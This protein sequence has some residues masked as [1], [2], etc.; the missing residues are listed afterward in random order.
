[1]R[2]ARL[3]ILLVM[4]AGQVRAEP[5]D[6]PWAEQ[7]TAIE[8]GIRASLRNPDSAK[9]SGLVV[10]PINGPI[11]AV[12]GYVN[13]KNSSG[14]YAGNF[15]FDGFLQNNHGWSFSILVVDDPVHISA[16]VVTGACSRD[17]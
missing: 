6:T 16:R 5:A 4:L 10:L 2:L 3:T 14:R 17:Q 1:M 7:I 12:C 15:A 13:A 9:I 11:F 8:A